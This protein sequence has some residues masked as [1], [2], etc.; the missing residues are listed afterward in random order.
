MGQGAPGNEPHA[1]AGEHLRAALVPAVSGAAHQAVAHGFSRYDAAVIYL[2]NNATTRPTPEVVAEVARACTDLWA[3]PSSVHRGGQAVR[4][5]VELARAEVA[6]L[7]GVRPREVTF[8]SGGTES[9]HLA[10]RGVL[11]RATKPVLVTTKVEHAAVRELAEQMDKSGRVEVRWAPL[12][13]AGVVDMERLGPLLDGA[14][15][16]SVQWVNNETGVIQPVEELAEVCARAGALFHCDATQWVGKM[17]TEVGSGG[18]RFD[19]MSFSAHKWHGPKGVGILWAR[20]GVGLK[21]T[22]P[23]SQE[24]GRRGGTENVPGILGAGVAARQARKWLADAPARKRAAGLRDRFEDRLRAACAGTCPPAVVNGA[25]AACGRIWTTSNIGFSRLEAEALLILLS[26]RGL[27]ASAGAACSSGSLDPSPVLL[28]M[29]VPS[30]V[31][32]GSVR[33]SLSRDTSEAEIDEAVTIVAGCVE[34]LARM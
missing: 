19:L 25:D 3:N 17:P 2:D 13:A 5:A 34:R 12:A 9:I 7:I 28:A 8:T 22:M 29:G 15:L 14:T 27:C 31:A 1:P 16:A 33:F 21:A 23:G 24:L 11:E 6:G 20:P 4:H 26:E 32:H 18:P 10:L 30:E